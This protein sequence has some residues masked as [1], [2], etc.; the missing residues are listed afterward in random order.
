M[1]RINVI[2]SS[3]DNNHRAARAAFDVKRLCVH[4]ARD[5]PIEVQVADQ[6]AR[7]GRRERWIDINAIPRRIV[8][9]LS[10]VNLCIST[11]DENAER[12]HDNYDNKSETGHT[13]AKLPLPA[14]LLQ[15]RTHSLSR[16]YGTTLLAQR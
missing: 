9:L 3:D 1:K 15:Q 16:I 4:V 10:N 11:R 7:V 12:E 13:P 2:R 8:V 14:L 6:L 5:G